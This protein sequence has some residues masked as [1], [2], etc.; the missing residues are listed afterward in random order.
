MRAASKKL[1][2]KLHKIRKRIT[3][4]KPDNLFRI[5]NRKSNSMNSV[6]SVGVNPADGMAH[7]FFLEE[8]QINLGEFLLWTK[9]FALICII[10]FSD[11][12]ESYYVAFDFSVFY[13]R[14]WR[15]AI[16]S[17]VEIILPHFHTQFVRKRF[18]KK[19]CRT[20]ENREETLTNQLFRDTI[21]S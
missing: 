5:L 15:H 12:Y 16:L 9:D 8:I 1:L 7:L 2:K 21:I 10:Q 17:S 6:L 13:Q 4:I 3:Y 11:L 18:E 20:F 19:N 14:H